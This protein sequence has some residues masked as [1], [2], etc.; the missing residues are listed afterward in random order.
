MVLIMKA[1]QKKLVQQQLDG[2]L[3]SFD[4]L[5][6]VAVPP[7]GWVRAI[8]NAL[9]MTGQQLA[10]RL[11]TNRQRI[12]RIEQ[13]EKQGRVTVNTLRNVAEAMECEFVYGFVPKTSLKQAVQDQARRVAVKRMSRSNQMMRLEAQELSDAEKKKVLDELIAEI[14]DT[15]PRYLWDE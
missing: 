1:R 10:R 9:G 3:M 7:K 5:G 13:D 2:T 6:K 15:M 11:G 4:V 12:A 8:R 14:V